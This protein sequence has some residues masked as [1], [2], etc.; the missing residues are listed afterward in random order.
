MVFSWGQNSSGQLGHGNATPSTNSPQPLRSLSEI[1]L[2][3]IAAGGD[4]SFALSLSGTIFGWGKNTA[5]QLGL[6]DASNR[7]VPVHVEYLSLKKVVFI[8][9]GEEHTATLTKGGVVFTFGKGSYGQLGHNSLRDELR[10]RLVAEF[11]GSKVTQIACGS[12][13]V[14][15]SDG[16]D[17]S[18]KVMNI[19]YESLFHVSRQTLLKEVFQHLREERHIPSA[20]LNVKFSEEDGIDEGGVSQE[21]FTLL[22]KKVHPATSEQKLLEMNEGSGL[23]WFTTCDPSVT[24]EFYLLGMISGMAVYNKCIFNLCFP[25]VLFKKLLGLKPTFDDLKELSP[26]EAR[27][28]Q[29]L[30]KDEEEVFNEHELMPNGAEVLV[31]KVNRQK[32]VDLYVDRVFNKSVECHFEKFAKG[33]QVGCPLHVWTMFLPEELM[34]L[35]QGDYKFEWEELKKNAKYHRYCPTDRIIQNFWAV[36]TE[37]SEE[38]KKGFLI[39]LTASDRLPRG[40]CSTLQIEIKELS[41]ENPDEHYPEAETCFNV[42]QLPNYSSIDILREKLLHSITYC[43]VIGKN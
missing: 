24:D 35:L 22:T 43:D 3:Q 9:C 29:N 2:A 11:W 16:L 31:T 14:K 38:Q 17:K 15:D 36:F 26:I 7:D 42:L 39:F 32:Y 21:F 27:S 28:L 4:H 40:R 33:F 41:K 10:P 13:E 1:P 25:L 30:L 34:T 19:L 5:G 18:I 23:V 12:M 20:P 6:G 37:F 8:S